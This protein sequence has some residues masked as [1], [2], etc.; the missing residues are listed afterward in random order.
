MKF[1]VDENDENIRLDAYLA[2]LITDIS[3]SKLQNAIKN[4]IGRAHV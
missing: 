1:L 4:E 3:R 2:S